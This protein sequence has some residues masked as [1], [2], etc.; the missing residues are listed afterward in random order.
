MR[1]LAL[2]VVHLRV[3]RGESQASHLKRL[4]PIEWAMLMALAMAVAL[5][6][7]AFLQEANSSVQQLTALSE[8]SASPA[9][10]L[11]TRRLDLSCSKN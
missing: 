7:A 9:A 8:N 10:L 5:A 11:P 6:L 3:Y 2:L 1:L 4:P